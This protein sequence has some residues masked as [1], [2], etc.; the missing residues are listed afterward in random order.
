MVL[1]DKPK[2]LVAPSPKGSFLTGQLSEY[3][4]D[5]LGMMT[6]YAREY[7]DF[8]RL[9]L[10]PFPM[11]LVSDPD[12]IASVLNDNT[13]RFVRARNAQSIRSL[14]GNGMVT[15]AGSFW[16][17]QRRLLQPAF[18]REQ[19]VASGEQV[20]LITERVLNQ[21]W[22]D[23]KT[24]EID[25]Q[26]VALTMAIVGKTLFNVDVMDRIDTI[27]K[28]MEVAVHHFEVRSSNMFLIP[29]WLP[30]PSNL[31][32]RQAVQEMDRIVYSIISEHRSHNNGH[33]QDLLSVLL[34]LQ[35]EDGTKMTDR[36]V[37][38]EVMTFILAGHETSAHSLAWTSLLIAQHPE[39]EARLV[40]EL[41]TVLDGRRPNYEDIQK[42]KFTESVLLE[43]MRLYPAAWVLAR[44]AVEDCE[45]AGYQVRAGE[46]ILMSPWVM[47][48]DPRF[49]DNPEVF[50]P[51][52][53][54]NDLVKRLHTYVYFP[55]GGGPR[56][57]IGKAFAMMEMILILA[58]IFQKFQ[59]TLL[60]D[61]IIE[62]NP[63]MTLY[64]KSGIEM[65]LSH[66]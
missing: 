62:P 40:E 50:D 57:C 43:A 29:E 10:G 39:V 17:R 30:T 47:H 24:Y 64:P 65:L 63:S 26:L 54:E 56:M 3:N 53:W 46:T 15:S 8:V 33:G 13:G 25:R 34:N 36:Q 59:M 9:H 31:R 55:F 4:R 11:Y 32:Y 44:E 27:G 2:M 35:D 51:Q 18:H 49:F 41:K 12:A 1:A 23:G 58:S 38:D 60:S 7:G 28:A 37:R 6:R 20:S 52:R 61:Q 45:V 42:L 21:E 5:P 48:R 14:V 66:R 16:Q 19:I 22:Q